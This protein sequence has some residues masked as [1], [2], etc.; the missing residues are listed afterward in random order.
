MILVAGG[1]SSP[2]GSCGSMT[3]MCFEA[4]EDPP[5]KCRDAEA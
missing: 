1:G 2:P 4:T 5:S 3:R